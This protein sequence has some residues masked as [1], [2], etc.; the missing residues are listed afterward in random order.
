MATNRSNSALCLVVLSLALY[1]ASAQ[2][3]SPASSSTAS[4]TSSSAETLAEA[5]ALLQ[6]QQFAEAVEKL[7]AVVNRHPENPQAWFDLGFAQSHL[8]KTNDA[9]T[10]YRRVVELSP[11]WFEANLN[12]GIALARSGNKADAA[13]ALRNAVTLKP[14]TGGDQALGR[15]WSVLAEILEQSQPDEALAAYQKAVELDPRDPET[16]E[17]GGRLL[18]ARGRTADAEQ[19]YL[20]AVDLGSSRAMEQLI[21]LYVRQKRLL[22]AENWLR[23]YLAA[24]PQSVPAQAQLGKVLAAQGKTQ[25]AIAALEPLTSGGQSPDSA[26]VRQLA[27]LFLENKQYDRAATLFQQL[28]QKT[29]ND[30]ELHWN[31]GEGLLRQ[32]KYP[33][34]EQEL[35]QALRLNGSLNEAYSELA[36]AAEQNKHYQLAIQALDARAKYLPE[37]AGTYWLRAICYDNLRVNKRAI[38]NYKL[39]LTASAGKSPDQE[40]QA[41]H[42]LK[43]LEPD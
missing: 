31:F 43:A 5:E 20:K 34:A 21:N 42:R 25:D 40:F 23:K 14:S 4:Q 17:G 28:L 26:I 10:A 36:I 32:R 7:H 24:N 9:I 1:P 16:L 27:L 19:Q 37:N 41:R 6:K 2:Q 22:E 8:G 15:A 18:E 13:T 33:E 39:F 29:P 30:A 12:L 35:I 38:E 3:P 11:K